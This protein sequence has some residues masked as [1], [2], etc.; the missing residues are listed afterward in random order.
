[1]EELY[2]SHNS[3]DD[4]FDMSF[5]EHLAVLDLE[6]NNVAQVDQ[7]YYLKRCKNLQNLNLTD[8]PVAKE[9]LYYPRVKDCAPDLLVLDD[10]IILGT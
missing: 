8:N 2:L 3:I 4:L 9:A 5:L 6:G 7:L 1:L 10:E